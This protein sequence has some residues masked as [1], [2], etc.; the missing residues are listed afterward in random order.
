M[1]CLIV[2]VYCVLPLW[3]FQVGGWIHELAG[4]ENGRGLAEATW[5]DPGGFA[6]TDAALH[7]PGGDTETRLGGC[8]GQ[9]PPHASLCLLV[10]HHPFLF[11]WSWRFLFRN[12]PH[13]A[14]R[15]FICITILTASFGF[16]SQ[17]VQHWLNSSLSY[18]TTALRNE[19]H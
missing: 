7:G 17:M 10:S 9:S 19:F 5:G 8:Q 3:H 15:V 12:I 14:L 11:P 1:C 16:H 6:Q 4:S 18:K 2:C 13:F